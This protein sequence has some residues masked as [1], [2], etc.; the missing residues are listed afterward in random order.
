M[1][2]TKTFA[3]MKSLIPVGMLLFLTAA[4]VTGCTSE[5][6]SLFD[7]D[8]SPERPDPSISQIQ[9]EEGWL[10]GVDEVII[11]GENFSDVPDENRVYFD[12]I[13]G[14]V[15]S[16][17]PTELRVRPSRIVGENLPVKLTV[18]NSVNFSNIEEYQLDQAVFPAPGSIP[19]DNALGIASDAAGNIY[20][21]YQEGGVARGIRKWSTDGSVE[22][23]LPSQF[24][25][26]S[27]KIGP[28]EL[29]YG[30][31]NIFGIYRE[32]PEGTIDDNPFAVGTSGEFYVDMDFDE[33]G[34]LW[35]VGNNPNIFRIDIND[36]TVER[37]P[38]EANLRAVRYYDGKLYMGG[39]IPDGSENGSLEVWT[40]D[41]SNGQASNPQRY[42][43]ISEV[44]DVDFNILAI[45]F[46]ENGRIYMGANTGS[47]IYTWSEEEGFNEFY[48]G[49]IEPN[50]YSFAWDG[51][52]L[53]ASATNREEETRFAL[54]IDIRREG[55]PYFGIE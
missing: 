45:T 52:F 34:Y 36:G 6:T 32:T 16:S 13:P 22:Q 27:I 40:M 46:D 23:H 25:W 26:N 31:R 44:A 8:Y 28:D 51:E 21:S 3:D 15:H 41:I 2:M 35:T 30:A 54:K 49:L 47:G 42:L 33:E 48:P 55:A 11:T 24:N 53:I 19:N 14:I 20:F 9:P 18:R 4:W 29:V 39:R 38:F 50:G 37:F 17:T 10:A 7:P 5:S 43:N 1:T 12:G